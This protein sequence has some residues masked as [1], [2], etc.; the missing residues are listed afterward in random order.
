M[1][2]VHVRNG[3]LNSYK[4]DHQPVG[5]YSGK[6]LSFSKQNVKVKRDDMIYIFSDG[7]Q[8]QFGGEKNKKYMLSRLKNFLS[9][10]SN[11]DENH[12]IKFHKNEFI[13]WKG[14]NEQIDDVCLMGLRI[15]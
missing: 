14:D 1:S 4:G 5:F 10:I 12:P 9:Q 3:N 6:N 15:T 8:D 7:Y 2:L 13:S 11:E